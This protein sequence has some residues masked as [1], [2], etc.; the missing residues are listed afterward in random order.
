MLVANGVLLVVGQNQPP[1][2]RQ[3]VWQ[4]L[5]SLRLTFPG[6]FITQRI[7]HL[8][9]QLI[10]WNIEINLIAIAKQY[11]NMAT[12]AKMKEIVPEYKS[13]NSIYEKLDK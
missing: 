11:D 9:S 13:N 12:V 7:T 3:T 6:F 5:Q 1:S 2:A 10:I 8:Y 4:L